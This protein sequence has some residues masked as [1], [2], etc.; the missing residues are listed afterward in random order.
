M[1]IH[2]YKD[3]MEVSLMENDNIMYTTAYLAIRVAV[4]AGF[5][6]ALYCVLCPTLVTARSAGV[7]NTHAGQSADAVFDDRC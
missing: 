4:M 1:P 6:Y 7:G 5:G 3:A 2:S